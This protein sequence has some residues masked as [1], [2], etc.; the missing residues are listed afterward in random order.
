MTEPFRVPE[1][2]EAAAKAGI[3]FLPGEVPP[4]SHERWQFD[5]ALRAAYAVDVPAIVRAE[6]ERA[7]HWWHESDADGTMPLEASFVDYLASRFPQAAPEKKPQ[8]PCAVCG[9]NEADPGVTVCESCWDKQ[10]KPTPSAPAEPPD[11]TCTYLGD[12]RCPACAEKRAAP[13]TEEKAFT[14]PRCGGH[15]FGTVGRIGREPHYRHCNDQFGKGCRWKGD[16]ADCMAQEH[17]CPPFVPTPSAPAETTRV[18]PGGRN[19]TTAS[20]RSWEIVNDGAKPITVN[21]EHV[22]PVGEARVF[23]PDGTPEAGRWA[24]DTVKKH[25]PMSCTACPCGR[26]QAER[27][28]LRLFARDYLWHV[29][30]EDPEVRGRDT[31]AAA[32]RMMEAP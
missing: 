29:N 2:S 28:F 16:D 31:I 14:C 32:R 7:W 21:G 12:K 25:F 17:R 24:D 13:E 26:C 4:T 9:K 8:R 19:V 6:V 1:P 3:D 23:G 15:F 30:G 10:Y 5:R 11:H 27:E 20:G 18:Y 22:I